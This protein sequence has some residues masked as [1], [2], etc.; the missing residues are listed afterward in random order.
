MGTADPDFPDPVA[1]ANEL[2]EIMGAEVV[3]SEGSGHYP[4]AETPALV[5]D[6]IVALVK[7]SGLGETLG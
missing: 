2:A 7:K 5:A 3:W 6:A 4:Q 1:E